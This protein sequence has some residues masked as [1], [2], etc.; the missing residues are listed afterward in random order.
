MRMNGTL[1]TLFPTIRAS[2]LSATLLQPERWWI[3]TELARH[4]GTTPSRVQ[5]ELESLV[6]LGLLLRRQDGRRTYFKANADSP[7]FPDLRGLIEKTS[8]F[9]TAQN[10]ATNRF[11]IDRLKVEVHPD[12][13]SAGRAAAQETAEYLRRMGSAQDAVAVIFATGASQLDMLRALVAAP[14]IPWNKIVG[15]HLDEYVDL[16]ENHA[17]SF[18]RYLRENLTSRIRMRE[19]FAIDGSSP[20]HDAVCREYAERMRAAG[21]QLCL[22]GI[23]ENGHLAF[24]E[25]AEADFHDPAD[26][27]MVTLD[28]TCRQQQT[29]EGWFGSIEEVPAR[30]ITVTIPALFRVPRLILTIPGK[31]KAHI[32]RRAFTEPISTHCPA[33]VLRTHPDATVYLDLDSAAELD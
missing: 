19:F 22:L 7:L 5:R 20:D 28:A 4:L 21:P 23:G 13:E 8:G 17:A 9:E 12:K 10:S 33:T 26:V 27:K 24:N 3:V 14:D 30:A 2:V 11:Q 15:F 25:P 18:R 31:R 1:E 29:A 6:S 16:D 32:V